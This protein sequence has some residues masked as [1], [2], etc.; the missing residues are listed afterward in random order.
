MISV[1]ADLSGKGKKIANFQAD[2]GNIDHIY[3]DLYQTFNTKPHRVNTKHPLVETA[4]K[5]GRIMYFISSIFL[6]EKVHISVSSIT[7]STLV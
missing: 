6:S 2:F 5:K 4:I 7:L 1:G 3:T